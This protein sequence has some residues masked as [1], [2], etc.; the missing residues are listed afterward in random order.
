MRKPLE[1]P[2]PVVD[3][4]SRSICAESNLSILL[5]SHHFLPMDGLTF[6]VENVGET[7]K[8]KLSFYKVAGLFTFL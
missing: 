4:I 1:K 2:S 7:G 5:L 6:N 8:R 3:S